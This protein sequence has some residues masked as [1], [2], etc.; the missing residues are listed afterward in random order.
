MRVRVEHAFVPVTLLVLI[1]ALSITTDTFLTTRNITNVL[2]QMAILGIV[3]FG[4]T[5][6]MVG[7]AFDLSIGSQTALH[8]VVSAVVMVETGSIWL[9]VGAALLSGLTFGLVNGLIV[10][11][12]AINPFIATLGTLVLARGLALT[13]SDGKVVS[14]LPAG[15][16]E[17]GRGDL[18]GLPWTVV[19]LIGCFLVASYILHVTP[20]GLR[21]FAVGGSAKAAR[22]AGIKVSRVQMAA[23]MVSGLFAA[24]A[25][26]A[27]TAR[28]RSGQPLS[29]EL[30]ELYAIA[31]AVL[32]GTSLY[33][34]R[35]AV[36]RTAVGVAL[37]TV[38]Q[39]GLNLLNVAS[40]LQMIVI[41]TVFI[42][43]ALSETLQ[44]RGLRFTRRKV[45]VVT[46]P[47]ELVLAPDRGLRDSDP[48]DRPGTGPE[49]VTPADDCAPGSGAAAHELGQEPVQPRK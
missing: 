41:G 44:D 12:L 38:I 13:V 33:G 1:V 7:G 42:V 30:L 39:N 16:A 25:G 48:D 23:F 34:G 11:G 24:V 8:G 9:G 26:L 40:E 18:F 15:L 14:G 29:G 49:R 5:I 6:V 45:G 36:W 27:L 37:I 17:F 22:L 47:S 35:G 10:G 20:L 43:A 2:T 4:V 46:G 32:G 28:V 21:L 31:A 3:A 19:L